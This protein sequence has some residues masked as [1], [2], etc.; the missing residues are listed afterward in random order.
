VCQPRLIGSR[1]LH[2]HS[3]LCAWTSYTARTGCWH[4][5]QHHQGHFDI[6]VPNMTK[7]LCAAS[8]SPRHSTVGLGTDAAPCAYLSSACNIH[9]SMHAIWCM[10]TFLTAEVKS[11]KPSSHEVPTHTREYIGKVVTSTCQHFRCL[12]LPVGT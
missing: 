9:I 7:S 5:G 1:R 12:Q 4:A 11:D 8:C 3:R 6:N 2:Q 10:T